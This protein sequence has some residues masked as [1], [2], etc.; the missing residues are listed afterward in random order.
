MEESIFQVFSVPLKVG[1]GQWGKMNGLWWEE[2]V[3]HLGDEVETTRSK[4]S[5]SVSHSMEVKSS[6]NSPGLREELGKNEK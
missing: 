3:C 1:Q 4:E 6:Q 5:G 2:N